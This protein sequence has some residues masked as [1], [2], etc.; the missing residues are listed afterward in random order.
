[1]IHRSVLV[2]VIKNAVQSNQF[3]S[4]HTSSHFVS[5][6]IVESASA[7]QFLLHFSNGSTATADVLV[8]ADGV[9]SAVR[10]DIYAHVPATEVN[11]TEEDTTSQWSGTI[12]YRSLIQEEALEKAW[13]DHDSR[14]RP[15]IVKHVSALS[16]VLVLICSNWMCSFAVKEK[17]AAP[18]PPTLFLA[19]LIF[20]V[21]KSISSRI[22][23]MEVASS[24]LWH[25]TPFPA[26]MERS[27]MESQFGTP[28]ST[29]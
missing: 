13:P 28:L 7:R 20:F 26:G 14:K 1:M 22:L 11:W 9:H 5:Y 4:I 21:L 18:F 29:S 2:N 25:F 15:N 10:R 16:S 19:R 23:S 12:A 6:D 27:S 24:I 8:G 17:Y 3:C